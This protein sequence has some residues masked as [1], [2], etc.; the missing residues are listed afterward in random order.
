MKYIF[1]AIAAGASDVLVKMQPVGGGDVEIYK[2]VTI[3]VD[4]D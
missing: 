1:T 3:S 2:R 4:K